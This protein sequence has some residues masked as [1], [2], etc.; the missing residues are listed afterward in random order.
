MRIAAGETDLL[1]GCDLVVAASEEALAKLNER[2]ATAVVNSHEAATAEFTR[3]P[4]AQV[5]GQ[6]MQQALVEAVGA[7]KTH[8]I[9]ATRLATR[10]LG[11]SIATN[12]FMLGYAYQRGLVPVSAE[13]IEKAIQLNGVAV[14]LNCEAFL[15]GAAPPTTWRRWRS[16]P[17][18]KW[19]KPSPARASRRSSASASTSSP[20]TRTPA[21][22][23]ATATWSSACVGSMKAPAR[24]SPKP[25]PATTSRSSPTRTST[26]WRASTATASSAAPARPVQW[27]LPPAVPP[28]AV[29]A[30]QARPRH[31]ATAQ[32]QLRPVD[33]Q[34]LR[35]AGDLQIP[36]WQRAGPFAYSEERRLERELIVRYE[37]NVEA[38]LAH[39]RG[40]NY[41]VAVAIAELP[42]QIR[43]YGHVKEKALAKVRE[44]EAQLR[45]QLL[46]TEI[47]VVRLFDSAA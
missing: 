6:A 20:P 43:G 33:A 42:E 31:R 29:L 34:G 23:S 26:K 7:D 1:L 32:T 37:D 41:R 25:S 46:A 30:G 24:N 39:L 9:D 36:P 13:A 16:S 27:R 19:P 11:D 14:K 4:D 47:K 12:L 45:A 35:P 40:D 17:R 10:L 18:R 21:T 15:W 44:H 28:G 22:P 5:P 38:V 3:N 2:I 8:F